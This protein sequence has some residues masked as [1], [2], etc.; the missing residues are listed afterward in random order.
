MFWFLKGIMWMISTRKFYILSLH[1]SN[2]SFT[3][4]EKCI[5]S[6]KHSWPLVFLS[7]KLAEHFISNAFNAPL[8]LSNASLVSH[9]QD[10]KFSI[11]KAYLKSGVSQWHSRLLIELQPISGCSSTPH[12]LLSWDRIATIRHAFLLMHIRMKRH[13]KQSKR[14]MH[15]TAIHPRTS[16][17][18]SN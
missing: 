8:L 18:L 2:P 3:C 9:S 14:I 5:V 4:E 15:S 12:K 6:I 10:R 17:L 1:C 13:S 11:V 7:S 16:S